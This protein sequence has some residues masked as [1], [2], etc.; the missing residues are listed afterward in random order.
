MNS[1][2]NF[3]TYMTKNIIDKLNKLRY[4]VRT[5]SIALY[6]EDELEDISTPTLYIDGVP[7]ARGSNKLYNK[8]ADP[9]NK[10]NKVSYSRPPAKYLKDNVKNTD[11]KTKAK[12]SLAEIIEIY[13]NGFSIA[14]IYKKDILKVT[15]ILSDTIYKLESAMDSDLAKKFINIIEPFYKVILDNKEFT[16]KEDIKDIDTIPVLGFDNMMLD[17]IDNK[18]THKLDLSDILV[19]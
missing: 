16:L 17:N 18:P 19:E 10:Q 2:K 9:Y 3:D 15:T 1:I 8:Y 13:N 11:L 5:T 14:L 7:I 4:Y 6:N 12:I